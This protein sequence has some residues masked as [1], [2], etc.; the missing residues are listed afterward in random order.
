M[1]TVDDCLDRDT[2][3]RKLKAKQENKVC[4]D[5]KAKNPSWAS[6]TYGVFICLDC[7]A[8]HRSLGV[9]ISFVRST[10]LDTWTAEQLRLMIC[11]GN[12]RAQLFFK[13]HG[14]N[15]D[16]EIESKYK[17][18]AAE[19]YKQL[20]VKEAAKSAPP[21]ASPALPES[22]KM[23]SSPNTQEFI[24]HK[25][26]INEAPEDTSTKIAKPSMS[27]SSKPIVNPTKKSLTLG[28]K[29]HGG[30]SVGGLGAKKL[31][32][33]PN[34]SLYEQKPMESPAE[35][36]TAK[37][38]GTESPSRT[39]RFSYI[40]EQPNLNS[41]HPATSGHLLPSMS[42]VDFF[43]FGTS[44]NRQSRNSRRPTPQQIEET[45]EAQR[46][47]GGAKSISSSQF[48]E[49]DKEAID[50][51]SQMRLQKFVGSTGISSAQFFGRDEGP[52][53]ASALDL[54]AG[55][56]ISRLALQAS[57]DISSLK[58]AAGETGR[59]L[60]SVASNIFADLQDRIG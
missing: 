33:K 30:K 53:N 43:D 13:Q 55:E 34:E 32:S 26:S 23:S 40:E 45:G 36:P 3:F 20:L 21:P 25:D 16:G 4:F 48:F 12:G 22:P 27:S 31:I 29:K 49:L 10:N 50:A 6:I 2:V 18:R 44:A 52:N 47:F 39:S 57:E 46:K 1:A 8:M 54:S 28:A 5:C 42:P 51:D 41:D 58:S 9:H 11:G 19:L 60:Q 35:L 14:W 17:S 15:D 37:S 59:K 56:L 24:E 38:I 7:S